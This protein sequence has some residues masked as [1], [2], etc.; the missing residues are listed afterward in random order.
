MGLFSKIKATGQLAK[1]KEF[2]YQEMAYNP[3]VYK[4]LLPN[5]QVPTGSLHWISKGAG[6]PLCVDLEAS[7][8]W[9]YT[10]T[11]L[12]GSKFVLVPDKITIEFSNLPDPV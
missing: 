6:Q 7:E 4:E 8:V 9:G 1:L 11:D 5:G 10:G 3:G 12:R 2:T